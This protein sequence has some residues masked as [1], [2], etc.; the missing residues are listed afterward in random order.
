MQALTRWLSSSSRSSASAGALTGPELSAWLERQGVPRGLM[1]TGPPGTGKSMCIDLFF[2][3]L[4]VRYKVRRHYHHLLLEIYRVIWLEAEARRKR[5]RGGRPPRPLVKTQEH[6]NPSAA[7]PREV[8]VDTKAA[9]DAGAGAQ[10][11]EK[12]EEAADDGHGKVVSLHREREDFVSGTEDIQRATV[13]PQYGTGVYWKRGG[14]EGKGSGWRRVLKGMPFFRPD[15]LNPGMGTPEPAGETLE[16]EAAELEKIATNPAAALG[17]GG[18]ASQTTLALHAASHLFLTHG[19]VLLFDEVQL[20]DV[21]SAGLLRRVLEAYWRLGGVVVAT[22]NRLPEDLYR[23][24]VQREQLVAFLETL[25]ERCE[26]VEMRGQRDFRREPAQAW[27]RLLA[28]AEAS[29]QAG[30]EADA[31]AE[32]VA[33]GEDNASAPT[34]SSLGA[35]LRS[36]ETAAHKDDATAQQAAALAQTGNG[37][38]LASYFVA[39]QSEAFDR[40]VEKAI[41]GRT[42]APSHVTVYGRRVRVPFSIRSPG[43]AGASSTDGSATS[44][45]VARFSFP[46][47]CDTPLGPADYLTLASTYRTIILTDVPQLPIVL[48]NQARRLIT[49]LDAAYEAGCQLLVHAA[50]SPDDLFFPDAVKDARYN[51]FL[52]RALDDDNAEDGQRRLYAAPD[53]LAEGRGEPHDVVDMSARGAPS[54]FLT[55]KEGEYYPE[56]EHLEAQRRTRQE[57]ESRQQQ[58]QE[59]MSETLIQSETLSEAMQ[60]T[61]EGFRPVSNG[62]AALIALIERDR[63]TDPKLPLFGILQNISSYDASPRKREPGT[64][65]RAQ[66]R[67]F[68]AASKQDDPSTFSTLAIFS[69]E[70]E[71]FAFQRAVSRL[72]EMSHPAWTKR[73][74]WR[75]FLD[76]E[77]DIW[78]GADEASAATGTAYSARPPSASMRG[79]AP[80]PSDFAE[81]ASYEAATFPGRH[82]PRDATQRMANLSPDQVARAQHHQHQ[83]QVEEQEQESFASGPIGKKRGREGPPVVAPVHVWGV[84][85]DWGPKAK[86]WGKGAKAFANAAEEEKAH[87]QHQEGRRKEDLSA[88]S[89]RREKAERTPVERRR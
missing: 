65:S 71:K 83:Q 49:F 26:G 74:A 41:A 46:E 82:L 38:A 88:A 59:L 35:A 28:E 9:A 78:A 52:Q 86:A 54:P 40:A 80:A 89:V 77:M 6:F 2:D 3:A 16:A 55:S 45:S 11:P 43:S 60:D 29:L 42:G 7:G 30:S 51:P 85:E 68:V 67:S 61:E 73:K 56:E 58:Q 19:H 12:T 25:K 87:H 4:P 27:Q 66:E 63:L 47:L 24:N 48:K 50:A 18:S 81:E 33:G 57:R 10:G 39:A 21:A 5:L 14:S 8:S 64:M 44:S 34:T 72:Y 70:D 76:G 17:G 1:L 37:Q 20:V 36:P 62:L 13:Q 32:G 53:A 75:P 23:N 22:S 84:R 31:A 79:E 15:S 69:G